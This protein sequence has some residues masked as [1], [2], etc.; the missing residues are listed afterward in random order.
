[1]LIPFPTFESNLTPLIDTA[2]E[3]HA[4]HIVA[5]TETLSEV[6]GRLKR[7]HR[8]PRHRQLAE[9]VEHALVACERGEEDYALAALMSAFTHFIPDQATS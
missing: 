7:F 1:M 3:L 5:A 9:F 4:G 6:H 8:S 2:H